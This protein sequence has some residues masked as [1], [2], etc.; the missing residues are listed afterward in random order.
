MRTILTRRVA[1]VLALLAVLASGCGTVKDNPAAT[2]NGTGITVESVQDEL[3]TIRDNK[4]YRT[5]LE[6]S[7]G[8][9]LAGVGKGTFDSAFVAQLLSL[10]V[11]YEL[12]EQSLAEQGVKVSASDDSKALATVQQQLASL[13]KG[14]TKAFPTEY[15]KRLAHQQALIEKAQDEAQNGDIAARYFAAHRSEFTQACVSHILVTK[16]GR[17]PAEAETLAAQLKAQLDG[18][19]DFATLAKASSE[20]PGSKDTG[21]DLDCGAKGRFV[22]AF[23]EEV[24]SLPVGDVSEPVMTEF[25]YHLILVR[26]RSTAKLDDVRQDVGQKALDSYLLELTCGKRTKVTINPRYGS[27]DKAACEGKQ[28]LARV[29]APPAPRTETTTGVPGSLPPSEPSAP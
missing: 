2:I 18:G 6:E 14:V 23:E 15:R 1:P 27:W 10:R 26:T 20:D 9:K 17:S 11:Y 21:G 24:F 16:E 7:Y 28:G 5:A 12:L 22:P 25:G 19:A 3:S 8:A 13:G 4:A 29:A